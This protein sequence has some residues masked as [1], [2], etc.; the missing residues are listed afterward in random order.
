MRQTDFTQFKV[1]GW[2][3]YYL[4][5]VLD[6][7]TRYILVWKLTTNMGSEDVKDTLKPCQYLIKKSSRAKSP[8]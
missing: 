1:L 3:W 5:T 6:D 8:S 2:G 4:S 7:Y